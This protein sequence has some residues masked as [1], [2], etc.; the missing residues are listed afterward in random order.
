MW[1]WTAL[2]AINL[3]FLICK[4]NSILKD[5]FSHGECLYLW[6][7]GDFNR[8]RKSLVQIWGC[9]SWERNVKSA[10]FGWGTSDHFRGKLG[11]SGLRCSVALK[12]TALATGWGVCVLSVRLGELT[13][14]PSTL[15]G[16]LA[17]RIECLVL[18]ILE[19]KYFLC[20]LHCPSPPPSSVPPL[21]PLIL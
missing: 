5:N 1:Y 6:N 14:V 2:L 4:L 16:S 20:Q 17:F 21:G 7:A 9:F 11:S 13:G 12:E 15:Q 3:P 8:E 18:L 19:W 10:R